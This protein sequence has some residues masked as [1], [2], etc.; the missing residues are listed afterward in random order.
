MTILRVEDS[1]SYHKKNR[2]FYYFFDLFNLLSAVEGSHFFEF[3]KSHHIDFQSI[4]LGHITAST[5]RFG[6]I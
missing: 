4:I 3:K 6:K 5:C 2:K 1:N